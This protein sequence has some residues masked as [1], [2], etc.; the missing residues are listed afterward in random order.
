LGRDLGGLRYELDIPLKI[1]KSFQRK[2]ALW[3]A[4]AVIIG[5]MFTAR[6]TRKKKIYVKTKKGKNTEESILETG[7]ALGAMKLVGS[8][9]KPV[10]VGYA[11]QKMKGFGSRPKRNW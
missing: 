9:L 2:T 3:I 8:I 5:L 1:R 4:G 11:M 10:I 6:S 7:L